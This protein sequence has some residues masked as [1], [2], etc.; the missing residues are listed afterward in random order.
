VSTIPDRIPPLDL[1][2]ELEE[3]WTPLS[4]AALRVLRSGNYVLG[5][6]VE[7]FEREAAEYLGVRHAVGLNSGTDALLIGLR[8]IGVEAGDEVITTPFSFFATAEAISMVG[9]VPVFADIESSSLN[10]DPAAVEEAVT[11]RTV[12]VLPVHLFGRPADMDA[13]GQI[14]HRHGLQVLEDCA[15]SIGARLGDSAT[16]SIGQAGAF[17]FYPTKNLGGV[18]DGGLLTTND[19]RIFELAR[20]LR[21]HGERSRYNNEML[22]YN[23]RLDALQAALLRVKLGRLESANQGRRRAAEFYGALVEGINGVSAPDVTEGHVFH[24]YTVRVHDG[25]RDAVRAALDASGIGTMVYYPIPIHRLP[26]YAAC[27]AGVRLPVAEAAAGEVLSLPI[28]PEIEESTQR[29]VIDA[30]S[31]ALDSD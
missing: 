17:S 22:G 5:P 7:A 26:V 6:E 25:L 12:A 24:Q 1:L 18:G 20:M 4:E 9:A 15:Q 29:R 10:I 19:D 21:N 2:P 27:Y 3:L 23:S 11:D 8:C 14:S 13:I 16:G 31:R 28:W 30:L